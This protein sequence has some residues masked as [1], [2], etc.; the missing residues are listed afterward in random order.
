MWV[1]RTRRTS[2]PTK[3]VRRCFSGGIVRTGLGKARDGPKAAS[4]GAARRGASGLW[5]KTA[6]TGLVGTPM[7]SER[8]PRSVNSTV[9]CSWWLW[10]ALLRNQGEVA[11][12]HFP[13][14]KVSKGDSREVGF[15]NA[16]GNAKMLVQQ[17][18]ANR[19]WVGQCDR[20]ETKES[21]RFKHRTLTVEARGSLLCCESRT[22]P[23]FSR[24]TAPT[25][26]S[27]LWLTGAGTVGYQVGQ[28]RHRP[29]KWQDRQS[30]S[31]K[32]QQTD[33]SGGDDARREETTRRVRQETT[34]VRTGRVRVSRYWAEA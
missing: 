6:G 17:F 11:F 13:I 24:S 25:A 16:R 3:A 30:P 20:R 14:S 23:F 1:S 7:F 21:N 2:G 34:G 15:M 27:C 19:V 9:Y 33:K 26:L 12:T 31:P 28:A 32:G 8:V 18:K 4:G 10:V 29:P 5:T 22:T